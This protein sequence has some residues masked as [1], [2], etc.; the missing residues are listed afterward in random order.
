MQEE[1]AALTPPSSSLFW[2]WN[3]KLHYHDLSPAGTPAF[4]FMYKKKQKYKLF[5]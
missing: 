3:P 4:F 2:E 1:I 5:I